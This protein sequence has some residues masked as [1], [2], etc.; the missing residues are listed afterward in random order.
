[1]STTYSPRPDTIE[2]SLP[3]V[4]AM[5]SVNSSQAA[6]AAR[7]RKAQAQR[8]WAIAYQS[9][10]VAWT[11]ILAVGCLFKG[12]DWVPLWSIATGVPA[13]LALVVVAYLWLTEVIQRRARRT[14]GVRR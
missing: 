7:Q 5:N 3:L 2:F 13:L 12:S 4:S 6:T 14:R 11:A 10:T 9:V 8:R 1:M